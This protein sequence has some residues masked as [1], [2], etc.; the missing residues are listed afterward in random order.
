MVRDLG[1]R[2]MTRS[3][4]ISKLYDD[5]VIDVLSDKDG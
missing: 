5:A 4:T 3:T 2:E 1:N